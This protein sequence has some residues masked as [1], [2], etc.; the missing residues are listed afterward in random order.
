MRAGYTVTQGWIC[1]KSHK[2]IVVTNFNANNQ[3]FNYPMDDYNNFTKLRQDIGIWRIK[4][5]KK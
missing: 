4:T 2:V 1:R 5:L 3:V